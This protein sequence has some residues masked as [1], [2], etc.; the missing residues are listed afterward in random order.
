MTDNGGTTPH[1]DAS[2]AGPDP[3]GPGP[4]QGDRE[5]GRQ[6]LRTLLATGI[7]YAVTLGLTIAFL[8]LM[9][10]ASL[11]SDV[12]GGTVTED[13]P[14]WQLVLL[15][16][17]LAAMAL[18]GELHLSHLGHGSSRGGMIFLPLVA[19]A[20]FWL[21][22]FLVAS[23]NEASRPS[24][25]AT[26]RVV[27]SLTGAGAFALLINL[28]MWALALRWDGVTL[29]A[30]SLSLFLGS[31]V[32]G[33]T[34]DFLGRCRGAGD[35]LPLPQP[36]RGAVHTWLSSVALWLVVSIP[37]L[38]IYVVITGGLDTVLLIPAFLLNLGLLAYLGAHQV[39]WSTAG[40]SSWLWS[41][42]WPA[43]LTLLVAGLALTVLTAMAWHLRSRRTPEDLAR[44]TSWATLP[45]VYGLG[46]VALA[47][48]TLTRFSAD[49]LGLSGGLTINAVV[50][51]P[52]L[53]A[54]W[55]LVVEALSR[56]AAPGLLHAA[57]SRLVAL[58]TW[59]APYGAV[60]DTAAAPRTPEQVQRDRRIMVVTAGVFAGVLALVVG[61]QVV[62]ATMFS[63]DGVLEDYLDAVVDKD[64][65]RVRELSGSFDDASEDLLTQEVYDGATSTVTG[66]EVT[67]TTE[68][69][70][71]TY[72]SVELEGLDS[73]ESEASLELVR[74]G[75]TW[76]I[77]PRWRVDGAGLASAQTLVD[78]GT[79][80]AITVNDV[81][82]EASEGAGD[83]WL[84]PGTYDFD[85]FGGNRWVEASTDPLVVDP[86]G[87]W[88]WSSMPADSDPQPSDEA[89]EVIETELATYLEE[90]AARGESDPEGCPFEAYVWTDDVRDFSWEI[91]AMPELEGGY[92]LDYE[93]EGLFPAQVRF[94]EGEATATY[95]SDQSYGFGPP[96]WER[97]TEESTIY[98]SATVDVEGDELVVEFDE[99]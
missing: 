76:G 64:L 54:A 13:A 53:M 61:Y 81:T 1:T 41:E 18:G 11:F 34:A 32:L 16:F 10:I 67:D 6:V 58:L 65:D 17:H 90:C 2:Q 96:E 49:L 7:G 95:E 72:V 55:G 46:T 69:G 79:A 28:V 59:G 33:F 88:S 68:L 62:R 86:G 44:P 99:W 87:M 66:Y 70:D 5:L 71:T 4:A 14:S 85:P 27:A 45:V 22:T 80:G 37:V 82:V 83:F 93:S 19:T 30:A 52:L 39:P 3:V 97:E 74:D 63:P 9:V 94:T 36:W 8:V 48:L 20:G 60:E 25:P 75:S 47:L 84:L 35:S 21:A 31:L 50:W 43:A 38:V 57:P 51:S 29:H 40:S 98:L 15:P 26:A 92:E 91:T 73:E 77:F 78:D 89:R 56:V 12:D 24:G 42:S 23:R